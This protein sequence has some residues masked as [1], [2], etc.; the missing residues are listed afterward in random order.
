M[1]VASLQQTINHFLL[2]SYWGHR[3]DFIYYVLGYMSTFI[4][5]TGR[6]DAQNN[7]TLQPRWGYNRTPNALLKKKKISVKKKKMLLTSA[8]TAES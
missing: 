6:N 3:S 4:S 7:C 8:E 1:P 5:I 2:L